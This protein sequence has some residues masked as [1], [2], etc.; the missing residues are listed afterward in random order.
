MKILIACFLLFN[1]GCE[2]TTAKFD[3][4]IKSSRCESALETIPE[5][6]FGL[7]VASVTQKVMGTIFSYTATAG[8]YATQIVLDTTRSS[9]Y[10]L[11]CTAIALPFGYLDPQGQI[12]S[13][14]LKIV[15]KD[16][17]MFTLGKDSFK[18]TEGFRCSNL[19]GLS[20]SILKV[21]ACYENRETAHDKNEALKYIKSIEQSEEFYS[22]L[23]E[24][25]RQLILRKIELLSKR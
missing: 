12:L 17:R 6:E 13:G 23:S 10:V 19:N 24:N 4:N 7:K 15:F 21:S 18:K 22:C 1:F 3:S 16:Y 11:G 8:S 25:K 20:E 14:C 2:T 5:E 9:G